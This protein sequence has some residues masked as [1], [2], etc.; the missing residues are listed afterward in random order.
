[1]TVL[2]HPD[3]LPREDPKRI[4]KMAVISRHL[5]TSAFMTGQERQNLLWVS[6]GVF[7]GLCFVATISAVRVR[8]VGDPAKKWKKYARRVRDRDQTIQ[9]TRGRLDIQDDIRALNG[10][11]DRLRV[12]INAQV[13]NLADLNADVNTKRARIQ[14]LELEAIDLRRFQDHEHELRRQIEAANQECD[15]LRPVAAEVEGLRGR[16]GG[17]RDEERRRRRE[18]EEKN[19]EIRNMAARNAQL[20]QR[21]AFVQQQLVQM[22]NT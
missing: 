7:V 17:M 8:I 3:I 14:Q 21:M 11:A 4:K 15:R 12:T 18:V 20:V 19:V 9:A 10:A 22:Q 6:F 5:H 1:M 13:E 16:I 2:Q